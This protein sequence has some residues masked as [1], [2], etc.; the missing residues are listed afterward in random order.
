MQTLLC[1]ALC[2]SPAV[3]AAVEVAVLKSS[4]VPAW[5]PALDALRRAASAHNLVEYDLRGERPEAERI[6]ASLKGRVGI[7]VTLGPLATQV[8]T[9][10][11]PEVPLVYAM[12]QD[13]ARLGVLPTSAGVAVQTP[14]KNQ[15]AAFRL[16]YPRGVRIGVIY[17]DAAVG[18]LVEEAQKAAPV[19]RL[20][21]VARPVATE[22]DVPAT[23]RA[24]LRGDEA[25]DAL[26]IPPDQ[27]LLGEETRRF[28]FAE[29]LKASKPI[30]GFSTA[31]V[32][33][34]AL[35]SSGPDIASVGELLGELVNRFASGD[36]STRGVQLVPR[37]EL[38]VNKKIADKMKIEISAAALE[39]ARKA[40][41]VF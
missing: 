25:V 40:G 21:I 3:V 9:T 30:Y 27:M 12:V 24:L 31:L 17:A 5:R 38:V 19:V 39:E 15:L 16:V 41:K 26:W 10:L 7:V 13:P 23:L 4:E 2:S 22:K 6:T 14:I 28:I 29:A 11:L 34:G 35:V 33:E 37:A 18:K 32:S 8:A 1:A 36:R 20:S